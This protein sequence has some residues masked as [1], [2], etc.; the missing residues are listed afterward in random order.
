MADIA[1]LRLLLHVLPD[2]G[3][4]S[5]WQQ[6][7]SEQRRMNRL[8]LRDAPSLKD[9]LPSMVVEA[10]KTGRLRAAEELAYVFPNRRFDRALASMPSLQIQDFVD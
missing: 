5:Y 9:R 4:A 8:I 1:R 7:I 2:E 3:W 6:I 10:K